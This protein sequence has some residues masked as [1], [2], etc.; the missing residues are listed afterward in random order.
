MTTDRTVTPSSDDVQARRYRPWM[1]GRFLREEDSSG[2][3]LR[4]THVAVFYVIASNT[5]VGN[6]LCK[7]TQV[8]L[9]RET[10]LHEVTV[11]SVLRDLERWNL[12]SRR[13]VN[14]RYGRKRDHIVV[15]LP[16]EFMIRVQTQPSAGL[17]A[18]RA[19]DSP[20][21]ILRKKTHTEEDVRRSV[22]QPS[23]GLCGVTSRKRLRKD[24]GEIV[25][26]SRPGRRS[27]DPLGSPLGECDQS[28]AAPIDEI[29]IR[30]RDGR[31]VTLRDKRQHSRSSS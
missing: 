7:A 27:T 26:D 5:G 13:H 29:R 15:H 23:T 3:R 31:V 28:D 8:K 16:V 11:R 1:V 4:T 22:S 19:S 21:K 20:K 2:Y 9:A 10:R 25:N 17:G 6:P 24:T 12:I 18:N 30:R 14:T